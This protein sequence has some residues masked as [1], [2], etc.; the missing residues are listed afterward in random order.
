MQHQQWL[1]AARQPC[2]VRAGFSGEKPTAAALIDPLPPLGRSITYTTT[3]GTGTGGHGRRAAQGRGCRRTGA[4][5]RRLQNSQGVLLPGARRTHSSESRAA[6]CAEPRRLTSCHRGLIATARRH[7][8]RR[9]RSAA[10]FQVLVLVGGGPLAQ[11]ADC[12]GQEQRDSSFVRSS[13]RQAASDRA[14]PSGRAL[15]PLFAQPTPGCHR[16][17]QVFAVPG[18][19]QGTRDRAFHTR[20]RGTRRRIPTRPVGRARR[21]HREGAGGGG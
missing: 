20:K 19:Q 9:A 14:S 21:P 4:G 18:C 3:V 11:G 1:P 6:A 8:G 13:R 2:G 16:T 10:P 7:R 12:A 5:S 15:K 17:Q